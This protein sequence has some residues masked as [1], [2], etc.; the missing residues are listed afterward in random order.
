MLS[1]SNVY[2][3]GPFYLLI[4]YYRYVLELQEIF[5]LIFNLSVEYDMG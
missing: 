2:F 1:V 4:S 5:N 3:V